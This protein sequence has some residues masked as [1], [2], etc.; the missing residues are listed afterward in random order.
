MSANPVSPR[1]A[2]S[3]VRALT[4]GVVHERSDLLL[5]SLEARGRHVSGNVDLPVCRIGFRAISCTGGACTLLGGWGI[6]CPGMVEVG[7]T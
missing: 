7:W 2:P 6:V 3:W 1:V 4:S 5:G